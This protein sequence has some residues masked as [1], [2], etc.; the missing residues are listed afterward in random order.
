MFGTT[1][2]DGYAK[3]ARCTEKKREKQDAYCK[4]KAEEAAAAAEEAAASAEEGAPA[5][6]ASAE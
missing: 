2:P 3:E 1:L 5:E 4:A 6:E